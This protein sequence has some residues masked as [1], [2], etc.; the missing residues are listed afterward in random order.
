[1]IHGEQ[2]DATTVALRRR[3]RPE[4]AAGSSMD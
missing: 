4:E 1:M 3:S 2:V